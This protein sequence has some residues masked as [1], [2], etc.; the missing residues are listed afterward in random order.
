MIHSLERTTAFLALALVFTLTPALAEE[1][2]PGQVR[3]PLEDYTQ[4]I[5]STREISLRAP[6]AYALG[7]ANV[8]VA[9]TEVE[10]RAAATIRVG[11]TI[12]V[13]EDEWVSIPVLPSGTP[14]D[15]VTV[16]GKPVRLVSA[17]DGLCWST[18]QAGAY[19]MDLSYTVDAHASQAGFTLAVPLPRAAATQLDATLPGADLDATVIP[20][21]GTRSV[22]V[23]E[24]T[25]LTATIPTTHGVQLSWRVPDEL[26][27]TISRAAYSGRIDGDATSWTGEL[28]VEILRGDRVTLPLFPVG[29][30]L[31]DLKVDDEQA[32]ILTE[33]GRFATVVRGR[34]THR[35]SVGFQATVDRGDGPPKVVLQIPAIPVSKFELELPGDVEL[36]VSPLANVTSREVD[37]TTLA[38]VHVPVTERVAFTWSAAVPKE[39][40]AEVRAS[41]AIYHA[42]HAEEGVLYVRAMVDYEIHR[43]ETN[44]L[45]FSLPPGVQ[46]NR[47]ES[48]SGAVLDW[49]VDEPGPAGRRTVGVFLDRQ[50]RGPLHLD[51]YYDRSLGSESERQAIDVPLLR[52][53]DA[54]RQRGMVALLS[55]SEQTL[56]P[57]EEEQ[58]I[59]VGENQLP[60]FVRQ[61][62]EMTVAHTYKYAQKN[63]RLVVAAEIS[64]RVQGKFDTQVDTLV[65][66]GDVTLTGWASVGIN[67]KSGTLTTLQLELPPDVNLLNLTAPSLR[68]HRVEP[69]GDLQLVD[70]EFTQDMEGQFKIELSYERILG[71]GQTEVGV[72]TVA[73]REAEVEQGRIGVEALSAVEVRPAATERMSALEIGE[74]PRQ[75]VL[76]TS[77]PILLAYKYVRTES[78]PTL[79]LQVTRHPL[80]EIQEATIDQARYRS[81]FTS[82]GL[83]VTTA[84]FVVRNSRKPF[85]RVSLPDDSDVWSV[86]VDGK[87]EKPALASAEDGNENNV[88]IKI[89]NSAEGFP[90]ELV[91]ATSGGGL[92]W[93][94]NVRGSLPR[95][96]ILVTRSRWDVYLPEGPQYGEPSTNMELVASAVR[97]TGQEI[98]GEFRQTGVAANDPE[99]RQPLRISV[100]TAG[101]HYAFEKLYANQQDQ[102]TWFVVPYTS[103][104]GKWVGRAVGLAGLSLLWLG[105]GLLVARQPGL[106]PR[107]ALGTAV[108]GLAA[109]IVAVR[110]FHVA[111]LPLLVVSLLVALGL[112]AYRTRRYFHRLRRASLAEGEGQSA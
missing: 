55:N 11:L 103:A 17:A 111:V 42:V 91:Y 107:P 100:P 94:G 95:P 39:V 93:L 19:V 10:S 7:S 87:S 14:V 24:T 75:L 68:T 54:Q 78:W 77:N 59:K 57:V 45:A 44:R 74:L 85:L 15:S 56:S 106:A 105:I 52:A 16:G 62:V 50:L 90:V 102:D 49:R 29:V 31:S 70:I 92:R 4:L 41:A 27:Y 79:A 25:R 101:L 40:R 73:V 32:T 88:L 53:I 65:S 23:G 109:L 80:V 71:E 58:A 72:P 36:T 51:V 20:G 43:G 33:N 99:R 13:F 76:R 35:V 2:A 47:I 61:T 8:S 38:K 60:P 3:L 69:Q 86:F 97:A 89:I 84:H 34:G 37:G 64:D 21:A 1:T 67:I 5:E 82:D 81:L 110:I 6:S 18:D 83:L 66:I 28:V 26:G 112:G 9:V 98:D 104:G 30:T 63:P 108:G 12:E 22:T 48:P 46:I 96:D